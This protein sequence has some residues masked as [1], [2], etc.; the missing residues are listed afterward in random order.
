MSARNRLFRALLWV[1]VLMSSTWI[2]GTLFHMLVIGPTW[3]ASPPE[4]LRTLYLETEYGQHIWKVFGPP[5]LLAR[6][7][8]VVAALVVGWHLRAQRWLLLFVTACQILGVVA[9]LVYIYP[10]NDILF[11]HAGG[12]LPREEVRAL[13]G[14]WIFLDCVRYAVGV[15]AFLALL[16]AFTLPVPTRSQPLANE[17]AAV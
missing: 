11:F 2:G 14:R 6:N 8:P 4:S 10:I 12:D 1:S 3:N 13:A 7:L 5:W 17:S 9:T 15:V 16:S